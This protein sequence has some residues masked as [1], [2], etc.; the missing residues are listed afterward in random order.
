MTFFY[1]IMQKGENVMPFKIVIDMSVKDAAEA[2]RQLAQLFE[3]INVENQKNP[4]VKFE[5]KHLGMIN[6]MVENFNSKRVGI[7]QLKKSTLSVFNDAIKYAKDDAYYEYKRA[8]NRKLIAECK[9]TEGT[10]L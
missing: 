4:H 10:L 1:S 8:E 6:D 3:R 9:Q 7:E 2:K 5:D